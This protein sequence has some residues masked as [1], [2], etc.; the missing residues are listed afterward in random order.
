MR[1][2]SFPLFIAFVTAFLAFSELAVAAAGFNIQPLRLDLSARQRTTSLELTNLT[3]RDIPVQIKVFSWS[4][5]DGVDVLERSRDIFLAP[6]IT[7]VKAASKQIVRF[8]LKR[9]ADTE[10][11]RSYRVFIEQIPPSDP[12]LR[13]AMEF[14][15]RFSVPLFVSPIRYSEPEFNVTATESDKGIAVSLENT[16]N[17]HL[18]IKGIGV[19]GSDQNEGDIKEG[20]SLAT[21]GNS[22]TG[23]GYALPGMSQ[24]WLIPL[25]AAQQS[26]N[27]YKIAVTTDYFNSSGRGNVLPAGVIWLPV[28]GTATPSR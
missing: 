4:Q 7:N 24:Q 18:K 26:S 8:R 15:L 13:A 3:D 27:G 1:K 6:P 14:R 23:N 2:P 28:N 16:G 9:G 19:Y 10:K 12:Q 21:A 25:S 17:I 11:E 5:K 20:E 22:S